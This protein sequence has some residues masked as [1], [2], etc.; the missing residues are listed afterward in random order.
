MTEKQIQQIFMKNRGKLG[1]FTTEYEEM[2]Q[3]W[4]AFSK[5]TEE[6]FLAN[7]KCRELNIRMGQV[8]G[9]LAVAIMQKD[10]CIGEPFV[11]ESE[12][13]QEDY[14]VHL[15]Y[16]LMYITTKLD[17]KTREEG[18]KPCFYEKAVQF[19]KKILQLPDK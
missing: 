2:Y 1:A 11:C 9:K 8:D 7:Y 4:L 19:C 17:M 5:M 15:C 3:Q 16:M 14:I 10:K 18:K 6:E 12:E 13:A